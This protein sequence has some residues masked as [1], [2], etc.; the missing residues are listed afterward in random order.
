MRLHRRDLLGAPE[1]ALRLPIRRFRVEERSMEPTLRPGQGLIAV[2]W[3]RRRAGQIRVVRHPVA[4]M[5]LVK[6]LS[7]RIESDEGGGTRHP[8]DRWY[9]T[10]DNPEVGVDSRTLGALDLTDSWLVVVAV[11]L[12]WM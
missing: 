6:R 8:T 11:P 4:P 7:H 5:W 10:A 3:R 12:R 1:R 9:V 2:R